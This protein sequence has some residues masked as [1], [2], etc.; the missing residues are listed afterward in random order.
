MKLLISIKREFK[1]LISIFP[2]FLYIFI[3][4]RNKF[5]LDNIEFF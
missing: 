2:I 1:L 3:Y 4:L 5:K